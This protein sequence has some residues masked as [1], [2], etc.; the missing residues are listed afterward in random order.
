MPLK[1]SKASLKLANIGI[2]SPTLIQG[3][4]RHQICY[5]GYVGSKLIKNSLGLGREAVL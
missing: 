4:G 5:F 3:V 2:T 1:L